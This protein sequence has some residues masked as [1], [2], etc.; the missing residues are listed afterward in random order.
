MNI[1]NIFAI[2]FRCNTDEFLRDF[3]KI[4]TYSSPFS[5][6]VIDIKTSLDF[7]NHNFLNYT[8][9]NYILPGKN[10]YKFNKHDWTCCNIHKVSII[11]NDYVDILD[12]DKVCIWNH[13]NLYDE[14]IINSFNTR[15]THLMKCLNKK[16]D[17]TL[18][19]YIEKI[20]KYDG[21]NCYFDKNIL[22]KYECNFLILIP[23]LNFNSDP[24][25]FFDNSQ[26]RIIY[27]NSNLESWATDINHHVEEWNK[28][29]I[30][31]NKLY[32]FYIEYRNDN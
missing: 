16:P 3:L 22:D 12:M 24:L 21:E 13:H 20:Q 32:N 6:M 8:N 29:R 7:I 17:T 10:T 1:N 5:F 18:L 19:F 14:D 30:L 9:K 15:S 27:F 26:I 25:L 11:K 23:L 2:G 31:I 4:R 28:L